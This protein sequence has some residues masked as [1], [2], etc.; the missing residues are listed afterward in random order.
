MS[1]PQGA[2]TER[3]GAEPRRLFFALWPDPPL[4]DQVVCT[5]RPIAALATGRLQQPQQWH[6]TLVFLGAV[7][8]AKLPVAHEAASAVRAEPFELAL[9]TLEYWRRAGVLCLTAQRTPHALERL[10]SVLRDEL[11]QRGFAMEQRAY[12]PHLTLARRVRSPPALPAPDPLC[13]PATGFVLVESISGP[14]GS[15]YT[16]LADWRLTG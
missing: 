12:R 8:A 4:R 1:R 16:V 10:V 9:D 15:I 11:G 5:V 6:V 7:P 13:W 14:Q 3:G 2:P